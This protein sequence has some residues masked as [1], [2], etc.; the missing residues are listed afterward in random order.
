M[1][2]MLKRWRE[3]ANDTTSSIEWRSETGKPVTWRS[4]AVIPIGERTPALDGNFE[5]IEVAGGNGQPP[6]PAMERSLPQR[7]ARNDEWETIATLQR[8]TTRC[9]GTD[10]AGYGANTFHTF[11]NDLLDTRGLQKS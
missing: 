1:S 4:S 9:G 11:A 6:A 5:D 2:S 7:P 3:V 8:Y 10:N